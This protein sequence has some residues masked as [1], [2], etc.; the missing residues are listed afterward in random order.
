MYLLVKTNGSKYWRLKYRFAAKEKTLALGVYGPKK[1]DV[2]L[3]QAR[4][5]KEDAKQQLKKG[6]DP[7]LDRKKKKIAQRL[8]ADNIF[9]D[10]GRD[11]IEIRSRKWSDRHTEDVTWTLERDIFPYVG[12]M[13]INDIDTQVLRPVIDRVQNR[14]ALETASRLRQRCSGIFRHGMALGVCTS[15]PAENLKTIMLSRPAKIP[16]ISQKTQWL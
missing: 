16:V 8:N 5:A 2:S 1:S 10:V 15:D 4:T 12:G 13:P 14:G 6:I 11:W 9:Q 3:S 7:G